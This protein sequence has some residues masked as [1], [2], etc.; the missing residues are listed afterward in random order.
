VILL[1]GQPGRADPLPREGEPSGNAPKAAGLDRYGDPLPPGALARIGTTRLRHGESLFFAG[2]AADGKTLIGAGPDQVIRFWDLAAGKELRHIKPAQGQGFASVQISGDGAT[3]AAVIDNQTIQLWDAVS[4]K[5]GRNRKDAISNINIALSADGKLIAFLASDQTLRVW[6]TTA[7]EGPRILAKLEP[8]VQ[9]QPGFAPAILTLSGD[10][11]ILALGGAQ[12]MDGVVRRWEVAAAR[13]LDKLSGFAGGVQAL[14]FA[15]NGKSLAVADGRRQ[16]IHVV[17]LATSKVLQQFSGPQGAGPTA[18]AFAPDGKTLAAVSNGSISLWDTRTGKE[19]RRLPAQAYFLMTPAFSPDGKTLAIGSSL[20]NRLRVWDVATGKELHVFAGHQ[21]EVTAVALAPDGK[22]LVT[23]S[24][25]QTVRL[26]ES[27]TGRE[28]R[29]FIR[30]VPRKDAADVGSFAPLLG[31]SPNGKTVSAGYPDGTICIWDAD[32]GKALRD[33]SGHATPVAALVF[34]PS[35]KALA[36]GGIDGLVRLWDVATGK[37]VR[38]LKLP[39]IPR[40]AGLNGGSAG[41]IHLAFSP[42]GKTLAVGGPGAERMVYGTQQP[43]IRFWEIATGQVRGQIVVPE[44]SA[45]FYGSWGG[46]IFIDGTGSDL[47]IIGGPGGNQAGVTALAFGS[48]GRSLAFGRGDTLYL[49]ERVRRQELRL[50]GGAATTVSSLAFSPDGKTLAVA[51]G[52]RSIRFWDVERGTALCELEADRGGVTSVAFSADGKTLASGGT[53]TTAL[54]WDVQ[55]VLDQA[56]RRAASL[57]TRKLQSLWN[58]LS[59]ADASRAAEAIAS[60]AAAPKETLPL[61]ERMLRPVAAIDAS[62]VA[63]LVANLDGQRYET[64]QRATEEL[65][66]LGDLA[67]AALRQVLGGKPSLEMRQRVEQLVQKLEEPI[68]DPERLRA[69]RAIEVLEEINTPEAR[70]LLERLAK[71]APESRLTQEARAALER[72]A[73]RGR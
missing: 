44:P 62:R 28:L 22:T 32:T 1:W 27:A 16:A 36:S 53:D 43:A 41:T 5:E 66:Q 6:D 64:R 4:G 12:G 60:L 55:S 59:S 63:Q 46:S 48:G 73:T 61:L 8:G 37:K 70:R 67:E 9:G 21:A 69:L 29:Q 45:G 56:R 3:L 42:D 11:K 20:G 49:W 7:A 68:K 51:G 50:L 19:V 35:G 15:P 14:A 13:E 38:E 71:G 47:R 39:P 17:D 25:D 18:P 26:W 30:P 31:F 52:Q 23:A 10:G 54:I 33:F 65:E 58:E 34:S 57:P 40:I 24:L 2:F 72:L